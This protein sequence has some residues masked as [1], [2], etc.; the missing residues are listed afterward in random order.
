MPWG[1]QAALSVALACACGGCIQLADG[2]VPRRPYSATWVP[3]HCDAV[4][5]DASCTLTA[6]HTDNDDDLVILPQYEWATSHKLRL[7][8]PDRDQSDQ[9]LPTAHVRQLPLPPG[10]EEATPLEILSAWWAR[11]D[12]YSFTY[13]EP[14]LWANCN[15]TCPINVLKVGG[16]QGVR[17][18]HGH[19]LQFSMHSH[20]HDMHSSSACFCCC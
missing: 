16:S 19:R 3:M 6:G 2:V 17:G 14:C 20:A 10:T 15:P 4:D 11:P 7:I 8:T 18:G 9:P 13:V 5:W 1:P 12:N